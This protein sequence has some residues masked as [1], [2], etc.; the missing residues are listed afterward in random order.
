MKPHLHTEDQDLT[1]LPNQLEIESKL[2]DLLIHDEEYTRAVDQ[3][4]EHG[5]YIEQRLKGIEEE[6]LRER[7]EEMVLDKLWKLDIPRSQI[8]DTYTKTTD[9][10]DAMRWISDSS[11]EAQ[12]IAERISGRGGDVTRS[13]ALLA[14]TAVGGTL[15]AAVLSSVGVPMIGGGVAAM[16][17]MGIADRAYDSTVRGFLADRRRIHSAIEDLKDST[18]RIK[19]A[20]EELDRMLSQ[21][22]QEPSEGGD[23]DDIT[24]RTREERLESNSL[25]GLSGQGEYTPFPKP[26]RFD[27]FSL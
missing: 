21:S 10:R 25:T 22:D 14:G 8:D 6:A 24:A 12:R 11:I 3:I 27:G 18:S 16:T 9:L 2:I 7:A 17:G 5:E 20:R 26:G 4:N 1:P 23:V 13:A 15:A 19:D